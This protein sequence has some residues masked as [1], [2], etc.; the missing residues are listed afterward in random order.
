M[1]EMVIMLPVILLAI[2]CMIY[3]AK[4]AVVSERAELALR[5]GLLTG[6]DTGAGAYSAGNIYQNINLAALPAPCATAPPQ[7]FSNS[8]PFPGPTSAPFWQ[9][10]ASPA[11]SSTC[12]TTAIGLGGA[13]FL[14]AHYI[15]TTLVN[16]SA[17]VSVPAYLQAMLGGA[18][19]N[20]HSAASFTHAAYP[21]FIMYCSNEVYNRVWGAI[22]A[23]GTTQTPPPNLGNANGCPQ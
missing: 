18:T 5:Y 13:Q 20:V 16:V 3:L 19:Q 10:D 22:T 11:P 6:F 17:N 8:A 4:F 14:A 1:I 23:G 15:A 2:F 7:I 12:S 9:P 21:G